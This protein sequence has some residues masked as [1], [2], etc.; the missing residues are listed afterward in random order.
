MDE[1]PFILSDLRFT[2][3]AFSRNS[4]VYVGFLSIL[5]AFFQKESFRRRF[6]N[7][8]S[9]LARM[10]MRYLYWQFYGFYKK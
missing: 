1:R 10:P 4:V 7:I 6:G 9:V 5:S 2:A 3:N 8:D